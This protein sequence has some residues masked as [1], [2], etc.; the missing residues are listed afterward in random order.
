MR[1]KS[2][3]TVCAIALTGKIKSQNGLMNSFRLNNRI[4]AVA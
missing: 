2:F 3:Q 1:S 4:K